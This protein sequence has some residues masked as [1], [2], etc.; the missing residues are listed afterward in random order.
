ML[1]LLVVLLGF[2]ILASH[3]NAGPAAAAVTGISSL[4]HAV[5][6][7][8]GARDDIVKVQSGT[9]NSGSTGG[10][11]DDRSKHRVVIFTDDKD[12]VRS[13]LSAIKR[14]GYHK[15][16]YVTDKPN[17][18]WNIK[19]G[20]ADTGKVD[21]VLGVIKKE[22]GIGSSR[23]KRSHEFKADD[24]DIFVNLRFA[25]SSKTGG[26]GRSKHRVVIFTD[27]KDRVQST[28]SAIK[29]LGYH[30]DS[31]ITD[32]PNKDWNIKWGAA[33]KKQVD[34]I[35]GVIKKELGIGSSRI[36]RS[37]EFE[38]DD[39]DIFVNLRFAKTSASGRAKH[40]VV[41]FTNDKDQVR[42]LLAAIKR[43]GYSKDSHIADKP[44]DDWNIKWGAAKAKTVDEILQVI[45]TEMGIPPS[46]VRKSHEFEANDNDIFVN[47]KF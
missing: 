38:A 37:H 21:E 16:S 35:L 22:L 41:I 19:W 43:L 11:A 33:G 47:L 29:R 32:E 20:A 17:E 15:D 26:S 27:D 10:S 25:K 46:R 8:A 9:G 36:K 3:A 1:R 12:R 30:K 42:S 7:A 13:T 24:N 2:G 39:N 44:N 34:E 18:D 40:E 14:L 28:L 5:L 45:D 31:Y 4:T 23:I 6:D